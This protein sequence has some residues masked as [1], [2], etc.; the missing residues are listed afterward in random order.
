MNDDLD[1]AYERGLQR[2]K[3]QLGRDHP[4]YAEVLTYEQR[5]TSNL[6]DARRYGYRL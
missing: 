3:A 6:V 1:T 4:R 5:L 2:L